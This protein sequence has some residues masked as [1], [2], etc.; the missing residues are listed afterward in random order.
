MEAEMTKQLLSVALSLAVVSQGIARADEA[1]AAVTR[2]SDRAALA[3]HIDALEAGDHVTVATDDGIVSGEVVDKDGDDLVI[4]QPLIQ[5]GAE[6]IVIARR[7]IQGLR[8]QQSSP[9][10]VRTGV[11]TLVVVAVVVG[12]MALVLRR[13]VPGP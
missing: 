3:V 12:V 7:E 4:D 6:R 1:A 10:Q 13:L 8:Y 2:V 9:H 5:G 11:T